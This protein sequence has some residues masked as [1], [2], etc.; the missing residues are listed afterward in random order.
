MN[1]KH[2]LHLLKKMRPRVSRAANMALT[3]VERSIIK[4]RLFI[5]SSSKR[6]STKRALTGLKS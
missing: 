1:S 4:M 3:A 5:G 2:I 6:M